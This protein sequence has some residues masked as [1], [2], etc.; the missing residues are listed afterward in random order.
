L[1]GVSPGLCWSP[2]QDTAGTSVPPILSELRT[3]QTPPTFH[4]TTPFT[5]GFQTIIDSYGIATY[6]EVNPGLFTVI[7]FPFL[8]A[9]MFGDLGHGAIATLAAVAM[10]MYERK[11]AKAGLG[12]VRG[13]LLRIAR[14]MADVITAS[15]RS[16]R[17][18]SCECAP[19]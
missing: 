9:V 18:S 8:F 13:F 15:P 6:Q 2:C 19:P 7:T 3:V 10:I 16:S 12:E 1:L 5:E 17:R 11:L 14:L 4:R